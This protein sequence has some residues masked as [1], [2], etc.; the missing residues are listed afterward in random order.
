[1]PTNSSWKFAVSG[2]SRNCG[3]IVMPAIA[4]SVLRSGAVFY[5]HLGDYRAIYDFDEDTVP[6]AG[7]HLD[8]PHITISSY[9]Q[10]AWIDFIKR[11]LGPFDNLEVFLGIGNHEVISPKNEEQFRAQFAG[12]LD[13]PRLQAQRREDGDVPGAQTYYHW[14]MNRSVDFM[15]LDNAVDSSFDSTQLGW[16]RKRFQADAASADIRTVIVGMH[17]ALPGSKS[18][19]HSMCESGDG[20]ASGRQVYE[21]LWQL[22]QKGKKV[23]VLASHSHFLMD[24]VYDTPYWKGRVIPGW[25]VGTAGAVRY[26]LP[27]GIAPSPVAMTDVY[28]YLLGTVKVDGS[29][30]FTF[31]QLTRDDLRA[32]NKEKE[33]GAV[34]DWCYAQNGDQTT[35]P[36]KACR[37]E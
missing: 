29:V 15:T 5:W 8:T 7:L 3:D 28:G 26:R 25:I 16:I 31:Q 33:P 2:D 14:V 20:I 32:A 1:M 23:Y 13:S 37:I 17:E 18:A 22:Q 35:R 9:E 27:Q 10:N 12:Y 4:A 34:V 30:E 24:D 36:D 21:E 6:P 19:G 11:Q